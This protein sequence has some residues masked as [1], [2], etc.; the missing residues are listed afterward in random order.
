M[1]LPQ[2]FPEISATLITSADLKI[3]ISCVHEVHPKKYKC[4]I[5]DK[6]FKQLSYL[7]AHVR[8]V[9]EG[10]KIQCEKCDKTYDDVRQLKIHIQNIHEEQT[11]HICDFCELGFNLKSQLKSHKCDL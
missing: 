6:A 2:V 1:L 3:H 8:S 11:K 10:L 9:H 7:K 5:C 4:D